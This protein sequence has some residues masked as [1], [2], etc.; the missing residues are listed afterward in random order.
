MS[1]RQHL[2]D[3]C[4]GVEGAVACSLMGVDGIEVE[5]HVAVAAP[6]VDLRS[7]LVEYSGILRAARDAAEAQNAGDLAE[8]G[9]NTD[10]LLTVARMVSRDYFIIVA[11]QPEGNY[12]KARYLLRTV[13]PKVK[14]EL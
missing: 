1:F 14:A 13:A 4:Q 8:I 7:L 6:A 10:R 2:A 9:I 11:L 12:G 3:V 5:T